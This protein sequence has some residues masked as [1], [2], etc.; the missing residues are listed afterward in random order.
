MDVE[1]VRNAQFKVVVDCINS[2]GAI[3]LPPLFDALGVEYTLLNDNNF[4]HFA[5]NP[6]PLPAHLKDL[7][8]Q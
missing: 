2:T 6:E 5:H 3:A 1:A 7:S 4:G 8:M